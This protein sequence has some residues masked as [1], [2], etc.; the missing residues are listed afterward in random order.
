[1]EPLAQISRA[2][3][4]RSFPLEPFFAFIFRLISCTFNCVMRPRFWTKLK[5]FQEQIIRCQ[6]SNNK[7]PDWDHVKFFD[8][9]IW[10]AVCDCWTK[11]CGSSAS[12][13]LKRGLQLAQ[14]VPVNTNEWIVL[15]LSWDFIN[16]IRLWR[17]NRRYSFHLP[18]AD[19]LGGV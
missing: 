17:W 12:H 10:E 15:N 14:I 18:Y 5:F 3:C 19:A 7:Y 16:E 9:R 6:P 1:M 11:D 8:T 13:A 2:L 4:S